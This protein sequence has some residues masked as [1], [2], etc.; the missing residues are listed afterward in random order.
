MV[1]NWKYIS[2][3]ISEQSNLLSTAYT[4]LNGGTVMTSHL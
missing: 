4:Q 1:W 3:L 2:P